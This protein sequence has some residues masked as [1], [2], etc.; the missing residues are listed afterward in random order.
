MKARLLKGSILFLA[1]EFICFAFL[2]LFH[3]T[4]LKGDIEIMA[5]YEENYPSSITFFAPILIGIGLILLVYS[6]SG[7][8]SLMASIVPISIALVFIFGA[9]TSEELTTFNYYFWH[10]YGPYLLILAF[11][12][13]AIF[14]LHTC[15][16]THY[17]KSK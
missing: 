7:K 3:Q 1:C 5:F 11:L 9:A 10:T 6:L 17:K 14:L 15:I 13:G 12:W 16:C 8:V 4:F 2:S